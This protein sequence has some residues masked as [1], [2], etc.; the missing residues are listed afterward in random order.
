M[1][2]LNARE[3]V[4]PRLRWVP[5]LACAALAL[6]ACS[7]DNPKDGSQGATGPSGPPGPPPSGGG[8]PVT[9]AQSI[10]A[11]IVTAD[12][13]EDGRGRRVA[14]GAPAVEHQLTGGVGLDDFVEVLVPGMT[15]AVLLSID[16]LKTCV[17][18]DALTKTRHD[19][20]RVLLA[21]GAANLAATAIGGVP[22][23]GQM[24]AT[25]VNLS[26]GGQTRR[27]GLFEG[28]LALVAFLLLGGLIAWLPIAALAGILIVIGA[29]MIDHHSFALL[30]NRSTVLDFAVIVVVVVVALGY[31]L[32]AASGVG[33]ALAVMLFIREQIGGALGTR[34]TGDFIVGT[35]HARTPAP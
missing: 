33:I 13:P 28:A 29:R 3:P 18:L 34:E 7:G 8:V 25:L 26:S 4:Q 10:T 9:S 20:N 30:R 24:G 2:L 22:G 11:S 5:L 17:V 16:T 12:V 27:S 32:I 19:S 21:Q 31:S 6:A 35:L 15:L 1:T 23:A 14:P